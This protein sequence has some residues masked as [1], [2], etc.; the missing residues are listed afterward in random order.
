MLCPVN[1]KESREGLCHWLVDAGTL[2][3]Y[4]RVHDVFVFFFFL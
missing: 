3:V 4:S 2:L 1:R